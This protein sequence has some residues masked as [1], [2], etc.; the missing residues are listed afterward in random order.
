M[1]LVPIFCLIGWAV[2]ILLL[3]R[4]LSE[5]SVYTGLDI[6][7]YISAAA[8]VALVAIPIRFRKSV[9]VVKLITVSLF[10][11]L[12]LAFV[13]FAGYMTIGFG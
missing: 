2:F 3:R 11:G 12:I 10:C 6:A 4:R 1:A 5:S 13:T 8:A 7:L 9:S